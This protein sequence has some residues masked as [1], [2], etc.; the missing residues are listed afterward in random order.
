MNRLML[1]IVLVAASINAGCWNGGAV[2][3]LGPAR[4]LAA[5]LRAG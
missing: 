4:A 5:D 1:V 3:V 2:R